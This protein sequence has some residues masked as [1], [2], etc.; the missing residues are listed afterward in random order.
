[1][2]V[3]N[4]DPGTLIGVFCVY[5]GLA[6]G[7]SDFLR[8]NDN[9]VLGLTGAQWLC[10]VLIPAGILILTKVR[11]ATANASAQAGSASPKVHIGRSETET[12][13]LG[14]EKETPDVP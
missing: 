9:K 5:Y 6:R 7:L 4:L 8:V 13:A 14:S 10:V 11:P 2:G 1:M 3:E 12:V